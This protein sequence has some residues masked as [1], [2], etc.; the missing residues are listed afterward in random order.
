MPQ[1]TVAVGSRRGLH[2]RPSSLFVEAATQQ[3]VKVTIGR[4]G[5]S[6]VD[7]RSLLSVLALGAQHGESVVLTA[8]GD[9]A[10][11]AVEELAT[12]LD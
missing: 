8:E 5:R 1:R 2:A 4:D 10:E 11:A 3:P 9:G 7:A 6:A 12:L